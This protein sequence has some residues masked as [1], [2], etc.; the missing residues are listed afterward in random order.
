[1]NDVDSPKQRLMVPDPETGRGFVCST[2]QSAKGRP[3]FLFFDVPCPDFDTT[4]MVACSKVVTNYEEA[5]DLPVDLQ[6]VTTDPFDDGRNLRFVVRHVTQEETKRSLQS[7]FFHHECPQGI[8]IMIPLMP[9]W[10]Q[11]NVALPPQ[12][13]FV[14]KA[15]DVY[16]G[17]YIR[18]EYAAVQR[19]RAMMQ[20][21]IGRG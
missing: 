14:P 13:P 17:K 8:M 20:A 19:M 12:E 5:G 10:G 7:L 3:E 4:W 21:I 6:V 1:M 18:H 9:E 11:G 15:L 2:D 16:I